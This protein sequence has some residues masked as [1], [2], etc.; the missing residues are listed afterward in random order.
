VLDFACGVGIIGGILQKKF[1]SCIVHGLDVNRLAIEASMENFP[2]VTW[3]CSEG[4]TRLPKDSKYDLIISNPPIHVGKNMTMGVAE[5]FIRQIPRYLASGG[6]VR[7][8][9]QKTIP[10]QRLMQPVLKNVTCLAQ[11]RIYHIWSGRK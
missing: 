7:L 5:Q 3:I 10:I 6:E 11:D 9:A 8:V 4:F 1:S 2:Q